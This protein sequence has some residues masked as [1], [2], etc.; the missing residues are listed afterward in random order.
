MAAAA[1]VEAFHRAW[2]A[3]GERGRLVPPAPHRGSGVYGGQAE[4]VMR[5]M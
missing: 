5:L 1:G 2:A 3:D 4:G